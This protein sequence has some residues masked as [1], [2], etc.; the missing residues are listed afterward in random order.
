MSD[1]T[2]ASRGLFASAPA[3]LRVGVGPLYGQGY[4]RLS[5]TGVP[6]GVWR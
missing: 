6:C 1:K 3:D 4:F 5:S 2:E